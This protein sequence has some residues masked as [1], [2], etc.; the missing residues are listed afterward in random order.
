MGGY[1]LQVFFTRTFLYL[2]KFWPCLLFFGVGFLKKKIFS[3][4][5]YKY[6]KW[7][8]NNMYEKLKT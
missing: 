6:V 3:G 2:C 5:N 4:F 7:I 8:Q 1:I